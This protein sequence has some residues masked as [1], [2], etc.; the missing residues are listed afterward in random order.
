MRSAD[1]QHGTAFSGRDTDAGHLA[2]RGI[3]ASKVFEMGE[4]ER[5]A[6]VF[7]QIEPVIARVNVNLSELDNQLEGQKSCSPLEE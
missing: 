7:T 2:L 4:A 1:K 5:G 3:S 6:E